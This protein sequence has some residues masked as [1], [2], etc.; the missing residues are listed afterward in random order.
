MPPGV[1]GAETVIGTFASHLDP[2]ATKANVAGLHRLLLEKG[3]T[4]EVSLEDAAIV[5]CEWPRYALY[6]DL[7]RD[8]NLPYGLN[9]IPHAT[10][11]LH[12]KERFAINLRR[13]PHILYTLIQNKSHMLPLI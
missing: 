12:R 13:R 5:F 9:Q 8:R 1:G 6:S 10:R 4:Q 7:R 11:E 2:E 3:L